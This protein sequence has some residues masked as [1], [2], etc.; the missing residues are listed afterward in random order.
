MYLTT[1][2]AKVGG[3][4]SGHRGAY[5]Y[6]A[7]SARRFYNATEVSAMLSGAGL[8]MGHVETLLGGAAAI[9]VA[10]K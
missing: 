7:E 10:T 8:Q 2:V 5:R 9:H 6:L 4:L 1:A 3:L